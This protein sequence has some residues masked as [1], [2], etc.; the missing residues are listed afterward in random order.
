MLAAIARAVYFD[1]G[2]E[3]TKFNKERVAEIE[4]KIKEAFVSLPNFTVLMDAIIKHGVQNLE[5]NVGLQPGVPLKVM[6]KR[7]FFSRRRQR[8]TTLQKVCK[9]TSAFAGRGCNRQRVCGHVRR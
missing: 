4:A 3:K 5:E 7:V 1:E 2:G 6:R 8:Y 9:V